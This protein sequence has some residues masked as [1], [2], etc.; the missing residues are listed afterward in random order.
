MISES[1]V[2]ELGVH[3]GRDGYT[4]QYRI[5]ETEVLVARIF[6]NREQR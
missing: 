3:F 4:I 6:H 1:G 5:D 2:R